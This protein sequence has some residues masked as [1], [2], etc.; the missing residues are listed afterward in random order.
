MIWLCVWV[1]T[2]STGHFNNNKLSPPHLPTATVRHPNTVSTLV[3]R[4]DRLRTPLPARLLG[5]SGPVNNLVLVA[6]I[7][8]S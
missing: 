2:G 3:V 8:L 6:R 4:R 5:R 7:V 1:S